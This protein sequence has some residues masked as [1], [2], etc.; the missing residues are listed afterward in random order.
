MNRFFSIIFL[1]LFLLSANSAEAGIFGKK[2]IDTNFVRDFDEVKLIE[3]VPKEFKSPDVPDA[4]QDNPILEGGAV[5]GNKSGSVDKEDVDLDAID[6][7]LPENNSETLPSYDQD[8]L[9]NKQETSVFKRIF[10]IDNNIEAEFSLFDNFD[11][12]KN[13]DGKI[14]KNTLIGK[15]LE[16]DISRTDIPSYLLRNQLTFKPKK[17]IVS[18]IQYYGAF[19]GDFSS[20]FRENDYDTSY[21]VGFL[22]FGA[23]GK[24]RN[25][26]NDFK[27]L[28]NPKPANGRTYMQN[29]IA[30]AYIVNSSI[31]HHKLVVGYSRNQIGKEGG[32]SS[33]ILPF[34]TRSQIA[35]NFGSTRALG[36][37][38]IGNY[39]L[40]D[41]NLAFNSSDRF[42]HT[43]FA[44]PEFTGWVD[45]KPLGKTDGRYGNLTFG[46]G[47]NAGH[48]KTNY[49]VG[50][51]Y[52]GYKYKRLWTNFEYG[53][54]DGYNGTRVST[55][56][57]QGFNY[58]IG[59]KIHPRL[60]LIARYDQFDPNRDVAH[61]T[62][63][64]YT[65][66]INYFIKGQAIRL[67]VNYVFCNN[68]NSADSHRIIVGTQL[69]L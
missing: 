10:D 32:A 31:P 28:F 29:F 45:F 64:E 5:V 46:G 8:D 67:I 62:R 44:G 36:V 48:N 33:Y 21:D 23:I 60:Q 35:R 47:L 42:F 49:T 38:L 34:V 16:Q 37:R 4:P 41:Y 40:M 3:P 1:F 39:S 12:D 43:P 55:N 14:D 13:N 52:V 65:A 30:D 50:S 69:L 11:L 61:D 19:Q 2:N 56:K 26:K 7:E 68:Q 57:A 53:I 27:I 15:I 66:G 9:E 6:D 54:A 17:G 51:F 20:T 22:Q 58:T 25:T 63:R 18:K 24:F 59:Y